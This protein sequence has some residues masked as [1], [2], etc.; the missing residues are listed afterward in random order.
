MAVSQL[1]KRV[2]AICLALPEATERRSHGSPCFFV[3]KQF[4]MLSPAG[5]H[6]NDFP[7]LVCAAP[8]GVQEALVAEYPQRFFRP[9]YVGSRGWVGVRLDRRV[10][11]NLVA[12]LCEDA[13]RVVAPAR[14]IAG[15]DAT[16]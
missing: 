11:W 8:L 12:A 3:G 5:H 14:L 2:R 7:H 6:D 9:P 16:S 1:E 10:D 15:L 4:V 13:Y